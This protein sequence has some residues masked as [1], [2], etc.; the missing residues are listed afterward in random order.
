VALTLDFS[1]EAEVY[2]TDQD[3]G[4][5]GNSIVSIPIFSEVLV[6]DK[7]VVH[8]FRTAADEISTITEIDPSSIDQS[9]PL[10]TFV[11]S[12]KHTPKL[13]LHDGSY[14]LVLKNREVMLFNSDNR[15]NG[16][17]LYT[18]PRGK[19]IQKIS[20]GPSV[21]SGYL[22]PW[23]GEHSLILFDASGTNAP[24]V[25]DLS[26][27]A[28][29]LCEGFF[30]SIRVPDVDLQNT[31]KFMFDGKFAIAS[32]QHSDDSDNK[33]VYYAFYKIAISEEKFRKTFRTLK[34]GGC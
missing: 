33:L 22:Q 20:K 30:R 6:D 25:I 11:F 28:K 19:S 26:N 18:A 4:R 17:L 1:S 7:G 29:T 15:D 2:G 21:N 13:L 5:L 3:C 24:V 27:V 10:F 14:A 32:F 16:L 34:T 31:L 8:V 9:M 23:I 12:L